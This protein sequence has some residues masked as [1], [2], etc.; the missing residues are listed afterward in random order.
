MVGN[1]AVIRQKE[2]KTLV[3]TLVMTRTSVFYWGY[4]S[5]IQTLKYAG[6]EGP[7]EGNGEEYTLHTRYDP[8]L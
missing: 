6:K 5:I 1:I 4:I 3:Y 7:R 8:D 2:L